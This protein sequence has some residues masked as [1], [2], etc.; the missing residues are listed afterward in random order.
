MKISIQ[1]LYSQLNPGVGS[2]PLGCKSSCIVQD[3]APEFKPLENHTCPLSS[4]Q[5]K[6]CA[7]VQRGSADV[8]FNKG[9]T[10]DGK[11]LSASLASLIDPNFCMMAL[12]PTIELVEDQVR[13]QT[14]YH[15]LFSLD[16]EE[17][18]D[19]L[20]GAE[21]ARRIKQEY[22]NKFLALQSAI[23]Y[24]PILLTNPDIFHL[25]I[26]HQYIHPAYGRSELPLILAEWPDL[27]IL[28]EFPLFGP[29]QEAAILNS[30]CFIRHTQQRKKRF[31]FTSA[32]PKSEFIELLQK[33]GFNVEEIEGNYANEER[34][35]YRPILQK[36]ELEFIELKETDVSG[37]LTQN[38]S[39]ILEQLE[40][41]SSG[42]GLIILNSVALVSRVTKQLQRLLPN[43]IVREIS[44][45]IDR[46]ERSQIQA[47]LKGSP[48]PVLVIG[49]SAVDVGVDFK[50]HLL[51]CEGSDSSTVIQRLGRLGRHPGFSHYQAIVLIPGHTPW[52][53]A[54]L[55][56]YFNT[57]EAIN[58]ETLNQGILDAF[59]P[60]RDFQEY[61]SCWGALQAQGMFAQM[62]REN[63]KVS[64][65]IR[66]RIT[67]DLQGI[68][69]EKIHSK[70]WFALSQKDNLVGKATVKELLRFRGGSA[71]QAAIW[72]EHRF[73]TYDLLRLIPH[74]NVEVI[75]REEFI[76]AAVG[77]DEEEFP[78]EYIQAYFRVRE[79]TDTRHEISL[80]CNRSSSKLIIGELSLIDRLSIDGHPQSEVITCLSRRK[81]LTFLV[82]VYRKRKS[83]HWD[84]SRTL[85]LSPLFGLYRLIDG[86]DQAYACAFNQDALLLKALG[87]RL[88]KFYRTQVKSSIF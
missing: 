59:S 13:Q 6:T 69:G 15:R 44:G 83:S 47:E 39:F 58:R 26:H 88:K 17:R 68:Y 22:R 1:P 60:P 45:R 21:L 56:D 16:A 54:R 71:L 49:T 10:G 27:W 74:A 55:Q 50:I 67:Q 76:Q 42:R 48:Q 19:C 36:I 11:T 75:N 78:D 35:G 41:E 79:W 37:W 20:F 28:D 61:R 4:H 12:Y 73:Y 7:E 24:K 14:E 46:G 40:Q 80:H 62:C 32:T 25:I 31:L 29:H 81:L 70:Q 57:E 72:D 52:V 85:N 86:D 34:P 9:K 63:A 30:M 5:A 53:T 2:C 51:I 8:I 43:V 77:H 82:P 64:Q 65:E 84:V 23:Y 66:D 33:A 87:G 18:I 3:K 38:V